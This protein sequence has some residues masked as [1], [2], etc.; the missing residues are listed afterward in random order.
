MRKYITVCV[1]FFALVLASCSSG[2]KMTS[3][4]KDNSTTANAPHIKKILVIGLFG[5]KSR[6]LRERMEDQMADNLNKLGYNAVEAYREYGPKAFVNISEDHAM[7]VVDSSYA[8]NYDGV[9]I[10]SII[11]K[12]SSK[13]YVPGYSSPYPYYGYGWGYSPFYRP[14]GMYEPGYYKTNNHYQFETNFYDI[15]DKKLLYS[16]QS[17]VFNP[18]SPGTLA[19]DYSRIVLKDMRKKSI[20]S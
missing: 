11:D 4:W 10:V 1:A 3:S 5:E 20:I 2:I 8:G 6:Q 13:S 19:I 12:Q 9:I 7:K 14:F 17:D 18:S 16:G 15:S